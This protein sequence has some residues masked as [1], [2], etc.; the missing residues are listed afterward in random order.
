MTADPGYDWVT[1]TPG[2][3]RVEWKPGIEHSQYRHVLAGD[4]EGVWNPEQ[5]YVWVSPD[6]RSDLRVRLYGNESDVA[7]IFAKAFLAG[8][9]IGASSG[10]NNSGE[11]SSDSVD[12][13]M[14]R[15]HDIFRRHQIQANRD[16]G[17]EDDGS[18]KPAPLGDGFGIHDD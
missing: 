12:S 8:V 1:S 11:D 10:N 18:P 9:G 3:Y 2:D 5:G 16:A 15:Q 14:Q 6:S 17:L 13:D 4:D 7:E